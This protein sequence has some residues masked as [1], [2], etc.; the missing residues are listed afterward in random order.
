MSTTL[1]TGA[2]GHVGTAVAH[3]LLRHSDRDL[4]LFVRAAD[5]AER[6]AKRDK[7]KA[8][9]GDPRCRVVYGDL[10][11]DEPFSKIAADEVGD[12][13]HS[14]AVTS[15]AVDRQT[16]AEVNVDGTSKLIAFAASCPGLRRLGLVSSLYAAGLRS[17]IVAEDVFDTAAPF[18]NHYE[19]SK[20][21]AEALLHERR[22]LPWQIYRVATILGEDA[23]GT[24]VQQNVIHNTLR[25]LYYGLLSVIPGNPDTRVYM[26]TTR[27]VASAIGRLFLEGKDQ[28]IFHVSDAGDDAITLGAMTD[29]VYESFLRDS[30][31]AR[32]R[33]LKPLF[34]D[35]ESFDTLVE[36]V[37]QFGGSMSQALDSVA[38]FAP[39][40]Y[41][42]KHVQ[43]KRTTDA[44]GGLRTPKSS[45]LMRAVSDYLVETRWGLKSAERRTA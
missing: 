43:T 12:I 14:A 27:F 44:L 20:W 1:I 23:G 39:Q 40:L 28:G 33:I 30:R 5:E 24:V 35:Q 36:S 26:V 22:E 17:G 7:L 8:L 34:C 37:G 13:L 41:S 42:D 4:L 18:A 15:F 16:A 2:D 11:S 3:W 38:P 10:R 25:L 21:S 32:Q 6:A 31:F 45:D 9:L 29:L 19:W